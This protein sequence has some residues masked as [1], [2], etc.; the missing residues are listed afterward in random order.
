MNKLLLKDLNKDTVYVVEDD[1]A[2]R[3]LL[4]SILT[5]LGFQVVV[6]A[7]SAQFLEELPQINR[8]CVLLLDMQL[9]D[10]SGIEL[11]EHLSALGVL[12]PIIYISGQSHPQQIINGMKKGAIDFL[13][14]PFSLEDLIEAV[15]KAMASDLLMTTKQ[16][17]YDN[18]TL[19]E[20]EVF[21]LL[22][23]GKNNKAVANELKVT[24]SMIKLHKSRVMEK[25][26]VASL[27]ALTKLYL[28]LEKHL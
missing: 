18:L 15:N 28:T 8:P 3:Q 7:N 26:H 24:Q 21:N 23:T 6:F 2:V 25:M 19:R 16:S 14:K 13:L 4:S 22:A 20:K 27:Q 17:Y 9:P 1:P 12:I 10:M 11:Q 5:N